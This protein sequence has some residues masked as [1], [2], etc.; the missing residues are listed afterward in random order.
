MKTYPTPVWWFR[1]LLFLGGLGLY[2]YLNGRGMEWVGA[3][4]F[5]VGFWACAA[6]V[7]FL[8]VHLR[9]Q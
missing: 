2:G 8:S 4:T 9:W 7:D 1:V 6:V 3:V 5:S